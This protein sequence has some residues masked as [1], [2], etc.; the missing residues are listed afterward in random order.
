[1]MEQNLEH[2]MAGGDDDQII[3]PNHYID[4]YVQVVN[5][6][7]EAAAS[8]AVSGQPTPFLPTPAEQSEDQ[9]N[10]IEVH[11]EQNDADVDAMNGDLEDEDG[12]PHDG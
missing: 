9:E 2:M 5:I 8:T 4:R 10:L 3:D 12:T 7:R 6:H 11:D 1:M